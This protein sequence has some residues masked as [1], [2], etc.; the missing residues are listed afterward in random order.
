MVRGTTPTLEFIMPIN[1]NLI[2]VGYITFHQGRD[3][4]LEKTLED[5]IVSETMISLPLTQAETLKFDHNAD[6]EIQIRVKTTDGKARASQII[7][8]HASRILKDGEI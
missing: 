1:T 3:V 5:C 6:V 4:V 2:E 7:N 8:T